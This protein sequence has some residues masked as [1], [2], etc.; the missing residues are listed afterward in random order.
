M[1]WALSPYTQLPDGHVYLNVPKLPWAQYVQTRTHCFLFKNLPF[2][3]YSPFQIMALLLIPV[4]GPLPALDFTWS[5][6]ATSNQSAYPANCVS[7]YA[8]SLLLPSAPRLPSL[9]SLHCVSHSLLAPLPSIPVSC[10]G[11]PPPPSIWTLVICKTEN[12][13]GSSLP[14]DDKMQANI[15]CMTYMLAPFLGS[16]PAIPHSTFCSSY[17]KTTLQM[18]HIL[19]WLDVF[20]YAVSSPRNVLP[21]P[22][23]CSQ[24]QDFNNI[25]SV[26]LSEFCHSKLITI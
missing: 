5:L 13:G 9:F 25:L 18:N 22:L 4:T 1:P 19:S 17:K 23:W 26:N 2:L 12:L 3:L 20:A 6:P 24:I 16:S 21:P 7:K 8:L 10:L 14:T 11:Q 15:L